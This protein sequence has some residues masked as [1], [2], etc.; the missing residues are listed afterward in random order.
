MLLLLSC[1]WL[2]SERAD[3]SRKLVCHRE[4]LATRLPAHRWQVDRRRTQNAHDS[5][6]R[7][8]GCDVGHR[9]HQRC[10]VARRRLEDASADNMAR[11]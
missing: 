10:L 3:G 2:V 4:L 9:A 6:E 5:L 7:A 8:Q 11:R 1:L